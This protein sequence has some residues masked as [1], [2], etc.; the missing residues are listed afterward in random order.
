M[1][2]QPSL[3]LTVTVDSPIRNFRREKRHFEKLNHRQISADGSDCLPAG[4]QL[5]AKTRTSPTD[6]GFILR[7]VGK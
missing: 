2:M 7:Y 5:T 3:P 6:S 1:K 4:Q